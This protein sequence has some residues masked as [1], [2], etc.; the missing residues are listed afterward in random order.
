MHTD[1]NSFSLVVF[2]INEEWDEGYFGIVFESGNSEL[3]S[4]AKRSIAQIEAY[5][6]PCGNSTQKSH[7]ELFYPLNEDT[8]YYLSFENPESFFDLNIL[9]YPFVHLP[10]RIS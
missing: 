6:S 8:P 3:L 10:F 9:K 5:E 1:G 4:I 7:I 2:I